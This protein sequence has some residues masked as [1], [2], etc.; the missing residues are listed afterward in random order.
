MEWTSQDIEAALDVADWSLPRVHPYEKPSSLRLIRTISGAHVR[1]VDPWRQGVLRFYHSPSQAFPYKDVVID[2]GRC[3]IKNPDIVPEDPRVDV[4]I[5]EWYAQVR[6]IA[7]RIADALATV[8]D[9][10]GVKNMATF[11]LWERPRVK[12][13]KYRQKLYLY[14]PDNSRIVFKEKN[15]PDVVQIVRHGQNGKNLVFGLRL[16][17]GWS[18][19]ARWPR[20]RSDYIYGSGL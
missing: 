7:T 16:A 3:V 2:M 9:A 12:K 14:A 4:W 8:R 18:C 11:L 5:V 10:G 20:H 13:W 1:F 15:I 6:A 19:E 17:P